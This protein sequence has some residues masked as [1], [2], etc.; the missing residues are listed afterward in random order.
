MN[1]INKYYRLNYL[2]MKRRAYTKPVD[3]IAIAVTFHALIALYFPQ[4]FISG[5]FPPTS[6]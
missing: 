1:R 5:I 3:S 4:N 6:K 2:I